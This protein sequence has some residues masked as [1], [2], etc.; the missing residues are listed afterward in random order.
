[1]KLSTILE[2]LPVRRADSADPDIWSIVED[3][4][5]ARE[6]SLFIARTGTKA[7]GAD[8]LADAIARGATAV[9]CASGMPRPSQLSAGTAWV[10]CDEPS[11]VAALAGERFHGNPSS[12][13]DLVGVTGTNGKTTIAYLVQQLFGAAGMRCGLVVTVEIDDG[14]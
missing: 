12:A 3:S 13:L 10:E 1:M 7:D 14:A 8:F 5:K 9:V 11:L 2:G 4:R 6:G